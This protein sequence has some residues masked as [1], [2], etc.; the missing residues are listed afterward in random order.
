[1][2]RLN[3]RIL[4][5]VGLLGI[6]LMA[7]SVCLWNAQKVQQ[8]EEIVEL[9]YASDIL[10]LE[11]IRNIQKGE[12]ESE[13]K[14]L[15][16]LI[17]WRQSPQKEFKNKELAKSV[18][19]DLIEVY[20]QLDMLLLEDEMIGQQ[21]Y[22]GDTVGA[23]ITET[24]AYE[25]WGSSN[26]EGEHFWLDDKEYTVKGIL[27][28]KT[29][30]IIIQVDEKEDVHFSALRMKFI[31][32]E[33]IEEYV[34]ILKL[35]YNLPKG[36]LN[37]LSLKSIVLSYLAFLPGFL[38]GIYGIF[39]LYH[40]IYKTHHY[41]ISALLLSVIALLISRF[42]IDMIQLTWNIPSYIIP[43]K[44]SDFEFWSCLAE[45]VRQNKKLLQ[46]IP[47]F[48]PDIWYRKMQ[49][50]LIASFLLTIVGMGVLVRKVKIKEGKELF[51]ISLIAII[52]SFIS[53]IF[54]HKLGKEVWITRTFW[55][56]IPCYLGI[57]FIITKWKLLLGVEIK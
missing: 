5:Y 25:L 21:L 34:E 49:F 4:S 30:N 28:E 26:V 54:V 32:K 12:A 48:L 44:W 39:K 56:I 17:A 42:M 13:N 6:T 1:M 52:I 22:E 18:E 43:N 10:T 3:K 14:L 2:I 38:L 53:I 20:G 47:S 51:V 11:Q 15:S 45:K 46:A 41:W 35:K 9:R 16:N 19:G 37:N 7:W 31:D 23:I 24:I 8:L 55:S 29:P 40:L 27:K 36:N 50:S 57:D 33:N